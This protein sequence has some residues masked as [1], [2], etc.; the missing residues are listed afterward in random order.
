MSQTLLKH[1]VTENGEHNQINKDSEE[2]IPLTSEDVNAE[3]SFFT[4]A[5]VDDDK[6]TN[7]SL[8]TPSKKHVHPITSK[9]RRK[10]SDSPGGHARN[11]KQFVKLLSPSKAIFPLRDTSSSKYFFFSSS[12]SIGNSSF[13]P[14]LVSPA[15]S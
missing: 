7:K 4:I 11:E 3:G 12:D 15:Q 9:F 5:L 14:L 10:L 2:I 13:H 8:E 1:S 6:I